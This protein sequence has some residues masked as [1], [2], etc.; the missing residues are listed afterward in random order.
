MNQEVKTADV[1]VVRREAKRGS[2]SRS[3]NQKSSELRPAQNHE[4]RKNTRQWPQYGLLFE[5]CIQRIIRFTSRQQMNFS[6]TSLTILREVT[7]YLLSL[8][9]L[10]RDV[11]CLPL[12]GSF[13][14][15]RLIGSKLTSHVRPTQ[16]T[17]RR[18]NCYTSS[19]PVTSHA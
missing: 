14:P 5:K 9:F 18:P 16:F 11:T 10:P 1:V 19:A 13:G 7:V 3:V 15:M 2:K 4:A 6:F 17:S 12:I 8:L